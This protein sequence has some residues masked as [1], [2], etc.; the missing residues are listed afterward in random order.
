MARIKLVEIVDQLSPQLPGCI[1]SSGG[2]W[3]RVPRC[4]RT[5]LIRQSTQI[6]PGG[7]AA[8]DTSRARDT[9]NMDRWLTGS[10]H[11]SP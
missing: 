1:A 8:I 9:E 4:G 6:D 5:C 3:A 7:G 10:S 11:V 2:R